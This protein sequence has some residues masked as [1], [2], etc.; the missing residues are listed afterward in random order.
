[1]FVRGLIV[2]AALPLVAF[3][4]PVQADVFTSINDL[5]E[6]HDLPELAPGV[7]FR[8]GTVACT[9][10]SG[11]VADCYVCT[12][13]TYTTADPVPAIY[14]DLGRTETGVPTGRD[15]QEW[16]FMTVVISPAGEGCD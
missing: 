8:G 11:P 12:D 9:I 6:Q 13:G 3:S 14:P 16:V 4:T 7:Q 5:L 2:A 1:M 10:N 15:G